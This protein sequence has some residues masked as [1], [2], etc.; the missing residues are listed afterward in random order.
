[1]LLSIV[2]AATA[3]AQ[4]VRTFVSVNGVD[5]ATCARDT[6][7]RNFAAAISA[8]GSGGEVVAIDSGGFG[9]F[10]VNKPVSIVGAPGVHAAI[11]APAAA[12]L[13]AAIWVTSAGGEV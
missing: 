13:A 9:P 11:A 1:V 4:A 10:T 12:P 3:D 6:P 7:C 2:F 8:V 5:N